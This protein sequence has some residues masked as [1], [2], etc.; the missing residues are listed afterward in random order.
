ML[1]A[2]PSELRLD[3]RGEVRCGDALV[4]V[5]YRDYEV[6]DLLQ[7]AREGVD[8]EP[9]RRLLAENR[10]VS[11]ITAELDA[12][13]CFEVLTEP[14]LS[15]RHFGPDERQVFRHHVLWTRLV[16]DRRTHLPNGSEGD[17]LEY[18]R[19]NRESL[20]LKPNRDYGGHGV[21]VGPAVDDG[22]WQA[23]LDAALA[24]EA[25]R[26]VVQ[27]LTS[28]PVHELLVRAPDGGVV[29]EP[30]YVVLGFAPTPLGVAVLGRA[31]QRHVVN[32]AQ[33]G[34]LLSAFVA[35]RS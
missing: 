11:S 6:R 18:A 35:P 30:Y 12:K 1:H 8:I 13:S 29:W 17:L 4:D 19:R 21:L 16:A 5:G 28:L 26:W 2:D 25:Q 20:V 14:V 7:L 33:R 22:G 27:R 34:G 24:D 31:S 3:E 9:M 23:A 10:M 15:A 32:I